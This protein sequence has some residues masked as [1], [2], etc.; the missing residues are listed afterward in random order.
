MK[1]NRLPYKKDSGFKIPEGYFQEFEDRMMAHVTFSES[2]PKE[3]PFKVPE[4]YFETLGD[5]LMENIETAPEKGKVIPLFNRRILAY[6][7][8]VAAIMVFFFST[9]T[10][11]ESGEIGFDDL[12]MIA[13][14]NYLLETLDWD[15]P[16]NTAVEE[17]SFTAST[18]PN[19]DKEA[20]LEYLNDHI[21]E[22]ALLLNED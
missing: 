15:N 5:K 17:Y 21:E 3:N 13:I 14:E 9:L 19:I 7:A 10:F 12:N 18:N 8:S 4:N 22:P 16:N 6:V 1:Q 11:N 20:L 2:A